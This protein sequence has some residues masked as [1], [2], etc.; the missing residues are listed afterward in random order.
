MRTLAGV[1]AAVLLVSAC[2]AAETGRDP[3]TRWGN[4]VLPSG[5]SLR[6]EI[7]DTPEL[8]AR[9]YMFRE[10]VPEGEGMVFLMGRLGIHPFWMKNCL[11]ALDI[12]WLDDRWRIVHVAHSVPPCREDP[13]PGYA[14][15]QQSLYV[16]ET[17]PGLAAK[18]G[19]RLGDRLTFIPPE[20][21]AA[22]PQ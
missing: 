16:L 17:A 8:Q 18:Q 9:G 4:M 21:G 12:I 19:L 20:E 5:R 13:C 2:T 22:P 1:A 3:G 11:T 6:V 7:A 14:P 15:M 10:E